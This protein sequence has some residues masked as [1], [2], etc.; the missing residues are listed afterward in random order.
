ML[1][2]NR[3]E[4]EM[5]SAAFVFGNDG[6]LTIHPYWTAEG[7]ENLQGG[8]RIEGGYC[9][10]VETDVQ[11]VAWKFNLESEHDPAT[12]SASMHHHRPLSRSL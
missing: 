9:T 8:S 10:I 12:T 4:D 1:R 11:I 7:S 3:D 2:V 5:G 6:H